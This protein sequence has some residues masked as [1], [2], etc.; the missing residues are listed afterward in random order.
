MVIRC[1][2]RQAVFFPPTRN[3]NAMVGYNTAVAT[4]AEIAVDATNGKVALLSHHTILECGNMLVPDLVSGQIQGG[5]AT[6]IGLVLHEA[7]PLYDVTVC[8]CVCLFIGY[9]AR[10]KGHDDSHNYLLVMS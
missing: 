3:N 5:V 1:C 4:L 8:L 9:G 6:G 7:L 2:D 10:L